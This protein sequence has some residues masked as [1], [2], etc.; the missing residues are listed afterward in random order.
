MSR[1]P[2]HGTAVDL[3]LSVGIASQHRR[4]EMSSKSKIATI[5]ANS[6][7]VTLINVYEVDPEKQA[8]LAQRLADSTE[9]VL[10][11]LPGFVSVNIHRSFDRTRVANYTQWA[12][13]DD[14]DRMTKSP[15]AQAEF[16]RFAAVAKSVSPMLYQV[17]SVHA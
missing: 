7:V 9:R 5:D 13:K 12:S 10:R 14:F 4:R 3:V 11:H 1:S 17:S 15:E 16:K 6:A 8:E 2:C